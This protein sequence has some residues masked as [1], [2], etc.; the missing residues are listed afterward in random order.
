MVGKTSTLCQILLEKEHQFE[1]PIEQLV[2]I[3][4]IEDDNIRKLKKKFAKNGCFLKEFPNN[5]RE[6]LIPKKSCLVIDDKEE[7]IMG[8]R[9]KTKT[10]TTLAKIWVH[11]CSLICFMLFQSFDIFYKRNPMNSVLQ[12]C[13]RL[14]L[15][16]SISNF[17]S[18]KR[19]LNGYSIK[20]KANQTLFDCFKDVISGDKYAYLVLDLSPKLDSPH[21]YSNILFADPR[22]MLVF[23]VEPDE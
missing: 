18:L 3:Y 23:H 11:H 2:Y 14:F 16:K 13:N 6:I 9:E 1:Y 5:L 7:E 8:D 15:F 4:T 22:P 20:L 21:V 12:Q 19:W 17:S 10:I